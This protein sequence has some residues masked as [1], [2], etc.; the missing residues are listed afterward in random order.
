MSKA[1]AAAVLAFVAACAGTPG[2]QPH[3][4]SVTRHEAV[5]TE[6][7]R[8]AAL[9][10]AEYDPDA[11]ITSTLCNPRSVT[12]WTSTRNPTAE[13]LN[14]ANSLRKVAADHRAASLALRDAEARACAGLA[15]EDRDTSPF[16]H[17]EDI[18]SVEPLTDTISS[19][20]GPHARMAGALIT[21]RAVPGMTS[22]WLQRVI[23]CHLARNA[24]LGHNVPEMPSCP[25]VPKNVT[26]QATA[27]SAGFSVAV[28][29][30][31]VDTANEVL[32]RARMLIAP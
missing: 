13:H 18:A 1:G 17:R 28:R 8:G 25:L 29:S 15:D 12:C 4:M 2:A 32:R 14:E 26:A 27:A 11:G 20:K 24:A 30:D 10:Q 31:D 22:Q 21:F 19:G 7:E 5:A 23:D 16:A 6:A 9:E 3:D